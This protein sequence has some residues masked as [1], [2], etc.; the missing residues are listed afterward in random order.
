MGIRIMTLMIVLLSLISCDENNKSSNHEVYVG[1]YR[2]MDRLIPYPFVLSKMSDSVMLYN[3]KGEKL[4]ALLY[5]ELKS[6]DTLKFKEHHFYIQKKKSEELLVYDLLDTLK[7]P[8]HEKYGLSLKSV[9]KFNKVKFIADLNENKIKRLLLESV[10]S[11]D[12]VSDENSSPNADFKIRR[13][14]QFKEEVLE[15]LTEYFYDG[16]RILSEYE[17]KRWSLFSVGNILLL[18]IDE[19]EDNPQSIYQVSKASA[20]EIVLKDFS[21]YEEK[22]IVLKKEGLDKEMFVELKEKSVYISRCFDGFQGEYYHQSVTYGKGN[23]YILDAVNKNPPKTDLNKN[24]Y[25]IAHFN[26]SCKGGLNDFGLIQMDRAYK[27]M[28]FSKEIVKHIFNQVL[29]LK[30]WPVDNISLS[31]GYYQDVHAF[32]MFKIEN[33]KITDLC[34]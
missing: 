6:G 20:G 4:I 34:P 21:A 31:K 2:S 7:F 11:H 12:V 28:S 33:G 5:D 29:L 24:G 19:G 15:E 30:D 17:E 18:S 22:S 8:N 9:A 23:K 10:L 27:K 14:Y 32:L 16:L 13:S 26:I 3:N 1:A 25:I